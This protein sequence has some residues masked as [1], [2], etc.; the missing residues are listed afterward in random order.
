MSLILQTFSR[1]EFESTIINTSTLSQLLVV[2]SAVQ[3]ADSGPP[4][5]LKLW[6]K[7]LR[8]ASASVASPMAACQCSIGSWLVTM[9]E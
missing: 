6:S 5:T 7:R 9:V 4:K 2:T 1:D 3:I 8:M